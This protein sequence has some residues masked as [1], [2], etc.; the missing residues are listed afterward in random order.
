MKTG[1]S[2]CRFSPF[3]RREWNDWLAGLERARDPSAPDRPGE[4]RLHLV[5]DG[6]M[7]A[8]NAARSGC[9][10]PTNILSFPDSP[11]GS[12]DLVLSLDSL[13]RESLLYGQRPAVYAL[14]LLAH[15]LAH[16]QGYD[17]GPEM[18]NLCRNMLAAVR[19]TGEQ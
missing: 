15:G 6:G 19:R 13:R 8:L 3:F 11:P 18:E 16:L 17:H 14:L 12:G 10:G 1:V 7:T 9:P 2:F 4:V 5:R